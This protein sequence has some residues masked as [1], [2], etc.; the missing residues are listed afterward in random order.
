MRYLNG[1]TIGG[2]L[3]AVVG[4]AALAVNTLIIVQSGSMQAATADGKWLLSLAGL[5]VHIGGVVVFGLMA[6]YHSA[7]GNKGTARAY[8]A[9]LLGAA[10]YSG[11][12]VA[13]FASAEVASQTHAYEIAEQR[14][15]A[16]FKADIALDA[17]R[18]EIQ[19]NLAA[20]QLKANQ[21]AARNGERRD[22]RDSMEESR[23]LISEVGKIEAR[24][25]SAPPAPPQAPGASARTQEL[26]AQVASYFGLNLSAVQAAPTVHLS[27]MILLFEI[28]CWPAASRNVRLGMAKAA[29]IKEDRQAP[30]P[31][32]DPPTILVADPEVKALPAPRPTRDPKAL[33]VRGSP[34]KEWRALLD[35]M[36][37]PAAGIRHKGPRRRK[38]PKEHAALRFLAWMGAYKEEGDFPE[39][40][41]DEL[42]VE[43]C[44]MDYREPGSARSM[45][46]ELESMGRRVAHKWKGTAGQT[47][48][49]VPPSVDKLTAVMERKG[50]IAPTGVAGV[51]SPGVLQFRKQGAGG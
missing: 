10:I 35:K 33:T 4:A 1:Y 51:V 24:M 21:R 18:L 31:P 7:E 47:W 26:A 2:V 32:P 45:R 40:A 9:M 36:D 42:Y 22:R 49:V 6:G 17:K 11:W 13:S 46:G 28:V 3:F 12:Q 19:G 34:S 5:V 41:L 14:S 25:P 39:A 20:E 8:T 50:V 16:K 43:F 38:E 15:D 30:L 29:R 44:A 23:K 27:L 48:S 37:F